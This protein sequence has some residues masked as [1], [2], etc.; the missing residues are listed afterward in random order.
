M[1]KIIL[2]LF[3]II[4][5]ISYCQWFNGGHK[6]I[7]IE[8]DTIIKY[9]TTSI[10][11]FNRMTVQLPDS[12]KQRIDYIIRG[13]LRI[14]C[15]T[16]SSVYTFTDT[17][18]YQRLDH[19]WIMCL[20]DSTNSK[21]DVKSYGSKNLINC[22]N[23]FTQWRG[24]YGNAGTKYIN[25]SYN[26]TI[27]AINYQLNYASVMCYIASMTNVGGNERPFVNAGGSQ[28]LTIYQNN[29]GAVTNYV[30]GK[31]NSYSGGLITSKMITLARTH[32]NLNYF[33]NNTLLVSSLYTTSDGLTN[34]NIYIGYNTDALIPFFA[35][36]G[37]LSIVDVAN[38][39]SLIIPF[40]QW[41]GAN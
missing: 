11:Y 3:L 21:L 9:D 33:E 13:L 1:K 35:I 14:K 28:P 20:N 30:N 31:Y 32:A 10:T 27:D 37:N 6:I 2:I 25:T 7:R 23:T 41:L 12:V 15:T 5:I 16:Y 22:G 17:T 24:W 8:K 19:F 40:L 39:N 29:N 26:P 4:P 36:G 18:L 34:G 38:I